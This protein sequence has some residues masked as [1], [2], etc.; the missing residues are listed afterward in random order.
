MSNTPAADFC[1][2]IRVN[3][4]TLSHEFETCRRSP[5]I[6]STAFDTRP[7]DLPPAALFSSSDSLRSSLAHQLIHYPGAHLHQPMTVPE[8][9]AQI[10]ILR[11]RY[12]ICGKL[13]SRNSRTRS[14]ASSRSNFCF[15]ARWL[16]SPQ[17]LRSTAR[18]LIQPAAAR[19]SVNIQ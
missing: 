4:F 13:F 10:P 8:K 2:R 16:G 15:F 17:D 18:N 3:Y 9:L 14:R 5:A 12:Q 11:T 19:S 6:S 7:P 1:G